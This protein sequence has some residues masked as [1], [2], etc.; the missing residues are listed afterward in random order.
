MSSLNPVA[1]II[2]LVFVLSISG[3]KEA[4]DDFV[5][6]SRRA[7]LLV[8]AAKRHLVCVCVVFFVCVYVGVDLHS[9]TGACLWCLILTLAVPRIFCLV[10]VNL[11]VDTAHPYVL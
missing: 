8:R 11:V 9:S 4:I 6:L 2:P 7:L 1:T 3:I 5:S 10:C